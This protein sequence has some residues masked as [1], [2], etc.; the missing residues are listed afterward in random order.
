M[1]RGKQIQRAKARRAAGFT[2]FGPAR[3]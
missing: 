3:P 2:T 1:S